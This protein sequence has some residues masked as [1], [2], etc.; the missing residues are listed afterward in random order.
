ML[1]IIITLFAVALIVVSIIG[2]TRN[3]SPR[4][5]QPEVTIVVCARDE[6]ECIHECLASLAAQ[7]YPVDKF[8]ILLVNH[9]S[10]DNTSE[11]LEEF[12]ATTPIRT[13]IIH[14][15]EKDPVLIAK[16]HALAV[17]FEQVDT[18]YVLLT[19]GDCV[20]SET[21]ISSMMSVFHK[22]VCMIGGF[23]NVRAENNENRFLN[24][25]Q[26][27]DTNYYQ[28]I[29]CGLANFRL[30]F[31]K[32]RP[33]KK[34]K[35]RRHS[36]FFRPP[37]WMGNNVGY[38]MSAYKAT[39][40]YRSFAQ[41]FVEDYALAVQMMDA[42]GLTLISTV[43]P[44]AKVTTRPLKTFQSLWRQKRRWATG[45]HV[46][47]FSGLFLVALMPI[48]RVVMPWLIIAWPIEAL[49]SLLVMSVADFILLRV[50]CKHTGEKFGIAATLTIEIFQIVLNQFLFLAAVVRWP[51]VWK[52]QKYKNL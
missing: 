52:G 36:R 49:S 22:D 51:V 25:L 18:E 28:S 35:K 29:L 5:F 43:D 32:K 30:I 8:R 42:T 12:A 9:L 26:N 20:A 16:T 15:H 31:R 50:V 27:L 17:A 7:D 39:G 11:I 38:R 1:P 21:W 13:D 46:K 44:G 33:S 34:Q 4:L 3:P 45:V 24:Y 10:V 37:V 2:A 41:S 40:G 23:V 47:N 14:I 19:D 6:E 48:M